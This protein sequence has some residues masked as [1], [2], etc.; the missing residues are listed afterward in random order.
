MKQDYTKGQWK[1]E[2]D[3]ATPIHSKVKKWWVIGVVGVIV[4]IVAIWLGTG[5]KPKKA[6]VTQAPHSQTITIPLT[7]P[8][9]S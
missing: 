6:P 1:I 7:L 4:I 2:D 5:H 8:A 3:I 9:Q